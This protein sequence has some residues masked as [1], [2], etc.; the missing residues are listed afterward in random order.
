MLGLGEAVRLAI[1]NSALVQEAEYRAVQAHA[2]VRQARSAFLPSISALGS[3]GTRTF[4]SRSLGFEFPTIPGQ[5]PVFD[6][7]GQVIGP[8]RNIDYRG[9][10][11]QPLFEPGAGQRLSSEHVL[12]QAST[13]DV[14][15]TVEQAGLIAA[16]A[17]IEMLRAEEEYRARR[18]DSVW[19]TDLVRVAQH[20]LEAGVNIGLDVT[21]AQTRSA[22]V[23][24][25]LVVS[26]NTRDRAR[27]SL[28]RALD[29][30]LSTT[31]ILRDSLGSL[32]PDGLETDE[33]AAVSLA[34]SNRSD[35]RAIEQRVIAARRMV[36]AVRAER[37]P[38]FVLYGEDGVSGNS[39]N[40]LLNTYTYGVQASVPIFDG[41]QREGRLQEQQARMREAEV[42]QMDLR[43]Q[44]TAEV[45]FALLDLSSAR[46][47]VVAT[48]TALRFAEQEAE[49]ARDRFRSGV[50]GD[51]DVITSSLALTTARVEVIDALTSYRKAQ[52]ALARAQGTVTMLP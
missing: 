50:A 4:N 18:A 33:Q 34:L 5:P 12:A 9:R 47:Q 13:A 51:A 22:S 35:L 30:P 11:T 45:R 26:R 29:Q 6:P 1:H 40:R 20:Q 14:Q 24:A 10:I 8:V 15:A 21:R 37:L 25:Q 23:C 2:R 44:V 38:T 16:L 41:L 19:A 28:L 7:A 39:Y 17:Y 27:L 36:S 3:D 46:Q 42:Q 31:L 32:P 43:R 52:V 48:R 49:Q